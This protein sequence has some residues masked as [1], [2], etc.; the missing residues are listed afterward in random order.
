MTDAKFGKKS[1]EQEMEDFL[2]ADIDLPTAISELKHDGVWMLERTLELNKVEAQNAKLRAERDAAV[3][4]ARQSDLRATAAVER[5]RQ[6]NLRATAA[7]ARVAVL[8]QQNESASAVSA[9]AER[10]T[11]TG[12][13]PSPGVFNQNA[14]R[15][16]QGTGSGK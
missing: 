3:E 12:A 13:P 14:C 11:R 16:F 9:L 8:Q 4:R 7:E 5:A 6:S 10:A 1:K 2:Y 15:D